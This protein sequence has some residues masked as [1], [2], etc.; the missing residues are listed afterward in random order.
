MDAFFNAL[1]GDTPIERILIGILLVGFIAVS[2]L[3]LTEKDKR[4]LEAEKIREGIAEP[5]RQ[6]KE[7][8]ERMEGKIVISK[9]AEKSDETS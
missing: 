6:M 3:L 9:K 7:S 4:I 2:R 1:L 8:I 5:L